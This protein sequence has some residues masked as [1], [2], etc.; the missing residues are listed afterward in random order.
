MGE[1]VTPEHEWA[2]FLPTLALPPLD[3]GEPRVAVVVA[4]HP[5]DETLG[6]SGV[7][8]RLHA[9]G[10]RVRLV[11][12]SDGEAAFPALDA[13]GRA[14]LGARRR[15]EMVAALE[16]QGLTGVEP[17]WLGLPDSG[18]ADVEP[19]LVER[20]RELTRDAD[21]VLLPWPHDPHPDHAAVGRAALAAA[22]ARAHRWSYPIWMWHWMGVD[23]ALPW[24]L[25]SAHR[26]TPQERERKSSGLKAFTS[27]LEP[28]PH[29]EEP[30]VDSSMLT[31]F[32]REDE[33]LFREPRTASA[34]LTRFT[35]LYRGSADPWDTAGS[36]YEKD[37]RAA[38]LAALPRERYR[39]ALEP[40]CGAGEL[41]REL[42]ARCDRVTAFDPVPRAVRR[43]LATA[44]GARVLHGALPGSVPNERVD[45]VVLSEILYYLGDDDLDA[46]L[47]RLLGLLEPGGDLVA[48]HWRHWAP[49]APRDGEA[50]H[51]VLL[52]RPELEPVVERVER[53]YVLHALRR[54]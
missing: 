33:V 50:A 35:E 26:L 30:I 22:P 27:Q 47:D 24:Q 43:A 38:L 2:R 7:V 41:T 28:G 42:L 21:V 34:P 51:R 39:H 3:L 8:Q 13:A 29:G 5:D 23:S 9:G 6:A 40:A 17:H 46:S 54:R 15:R 32:D 4:A 16:A 19:E 45:L 10:A 52:A 18:L 31:H 14:E 37:K 36:R 44:R 25:A 20:L 49:E 11:V 1:S 12:A 53:D 48:V